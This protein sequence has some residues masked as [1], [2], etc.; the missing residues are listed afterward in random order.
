MQTLNGFYVDLLE[1]PDINCQEAQEQVLNHIPKVIMV[2]HNILLMKPI[3]MDELEAVVKQ[4][5]A[6]KAHRPDRFT[7]NF[8]H[9]CWDWL[10]DEVLELVENSR[11]TGSILKAFNATFLMLVMKETGTKIIG[12]FRPLFSVLISP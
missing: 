8:F 10:K 5:A 2:D 7:T 9:S 12:K 3:D 11:R 6:N 1:E 4:L